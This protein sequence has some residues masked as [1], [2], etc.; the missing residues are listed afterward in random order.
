MT[1]ERKQVTNVSELA[2]YRV[3]QSPGNNRT[4]TILVD[5]QMNGAESLAMGMS[6]IDPKNQIP[7]H[8][9]QNEEEAKYVI[10]GRGIAKIEETEY[11]LSEESVIFCA[12]GTHHEILNPSDQEL[13]VI[14]V[15][16][17]PGPEASIRTMGIPTGSVKSP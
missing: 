5:K 1:K 13:C 14:W 6:L 17:P 15:Y 7:H 16:V 11:E 3:T 4:A 12:P 2:A 8:I 9:H 10:K